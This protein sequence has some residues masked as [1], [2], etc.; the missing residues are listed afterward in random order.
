MA[1]WGG[2]EG[3]GVCMGLSC[4]IGWVVEVRFA[5]RGSEGGGGIRCAGFPTSL[6]WRRCGVVI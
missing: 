3:C 1:L 2:R 6:E 4:V 5:W